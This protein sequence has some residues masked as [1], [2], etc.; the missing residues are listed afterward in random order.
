MGEAHVGWGALSREELVKP[1]WGVPERIPVVL[2]RV[3]H[4]GGHA[5]PSQLAGVGEEVGPHPHWGE[6]LH[7]SLFAAFVLEP[8]LQ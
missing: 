6:L 3:L 2:V 1:L 8:D 4:A 7:S 5:H